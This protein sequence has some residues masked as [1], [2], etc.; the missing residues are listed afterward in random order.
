MSESLDRW[1]GDVSG[2]VAMNPAISPTAK[3]VY[4]VL[5]V[6]ADRRT[7]YCFP[8]ITT[9]SEGVGR[10]RSTCNE[11]ITELVE[12]GVVRREARFHDG[13]QT[14]NGYTLLDIVSVKT[15]RLAD[16][17]VRSAGGGRVR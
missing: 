6:H 4:L 3:A 7:G 8:S 16:T 5:A 11:A 2:L 17:G 14:T 10:A 1:L 15:V 9:I 13:R 12:A